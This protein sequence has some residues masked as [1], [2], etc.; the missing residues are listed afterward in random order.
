[1]PNKN[2]SPGPCIGCIT[3]INAPTGSMRILV[4]ADMHHVKIS[5]CPDLFRKRFHDACINAEIRIRARATPVIWRDYN[6]VLV[7]NGNRIF[8]V[9]INTVILNRHDLLVIKA[10]IK[11]F[12]PSASYLFPKVGKF[13]DFHY[14]GSIR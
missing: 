11:C 6:I 1:M 7:V 9:C 10:S 5:G 2:Q 8:V 14:N 4:V 3:K 12:K 13:L